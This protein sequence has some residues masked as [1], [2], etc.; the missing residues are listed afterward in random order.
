MQ[1]RML[2][3]YAEQAARCERPVP[4][5]QLRHRDHRFEWTRAEFQTWAERVATA[6]GYQ[7]TVA[8]VGPADP[9]VGAP[10]QLAVFTR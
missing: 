4:T 10:S 7:V 2:E 1:R 6:H 9:E 3:K 5:G 8:P